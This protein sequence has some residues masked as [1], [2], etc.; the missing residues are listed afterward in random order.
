MSTVCER[1]NVIALTAAMTGNNTQPESIQ[2]RVFDLV[3]MDEAAQSV[4]P[5]TILVTSRL[6][7]KYGHLVLVGDPYQLAATVKCV[8]NLN[9][10]HDRSTMER[11][12]HANFPMIKLSIQYRMVESICAFPNRA[13]YHNS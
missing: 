12:A 8:Q 10:G 13:F 6:D 11:L 2:G 5:E 3:V 7:P 4:E 1:K 9:A